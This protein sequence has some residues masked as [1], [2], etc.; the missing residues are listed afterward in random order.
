MSIY[1]WPSH[2]EHESFRAK[3]GVLDMYCLVIFESSQTFSLGISRILKE[4]RFVYFLS[5]TDAAD[6]RTS[7]LRGCN[8]LLT[9]IRRRSGTETKNVDFSKGYISSDLSALYTNKVIKGKLEAKDFGQ[10]DSV[11]PF[12]AAFVEKAV[13]EEHR[14]PQHMSIPT[15]PSF[16]IS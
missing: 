2:L 5:F 11:F 4:G 8:L 6:R 12:L 15:F 1:P 3:A 7:L 9:D 16:D 13:S 10:L 14:L